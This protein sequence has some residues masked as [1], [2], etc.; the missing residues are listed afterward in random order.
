MCSVLTELLETSLRRSVGTSSMFSSKSLAPCS[1]ATRGKWTKPPCW[2]RSLDFCRNTM[3]K[4]TPVS[5]F[6]PFLSFHLAMTS[7]SWSSAASVTGFLLQRHS[8]LFN[9]PPPAG[10]GENTYLPN[11]FISQRREPR[12]TSQVAPSSDGVS[13]FKKWLQ[14]ASLQP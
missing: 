3:V 4:V 5:I 6:I 13:P 9:I 8:T 12:A 10:L 7:S 2:R 11:H 14:Q 1:L